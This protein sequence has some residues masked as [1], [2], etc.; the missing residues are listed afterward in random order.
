MGLVKRGSNW[1]IDY[2]D[3][4]G[5]RRLKVVGSKTEAKDLLEQKRAERRAAKLGGVVGGRLTLQQF[6]ESWIADRERGIGSGRRLRSSTVLNYRRHLAPV[7]QRIGGVPLTSISPEHV[8]AVLRALH[9]EECLAPSTI[10]TTAAVLTALLNAAVKARRLA[11][12]PAEGA[13]S[14]PRADLSRRALNT[15]HVEKLLAV[16][17]ERSPLVHYPPVLALAHTGARLG[18]V[19]ALTWADLDLKAGRI[20]IS[21]TSTPQGEI[22]PPKGGRSRT[23]GASHKLLEFLLRL[24]RSSKE[25]ALREGRPRPGS[26][27]LN[28]DGVA[29][30][31]SAFGRALR[32]LAK[33]AGIPEATPHALRHSFAGLLLKGGANVAHVQRALGHSSVK[34]TVD[35]Y[36]S[37]TGMEEEVAALAGR[38]EDLVSAP[39]SD[40]RETQSQVVESINLVK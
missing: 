19:L 38:Y 18:E 31:H 20:S 29:H 39:K 7:L 6:S 34:M 9:D 2:R 15:E 33:R 12:N 13:Y 21:K 3:T 1:A 11:I 10:G 32:R 8:H 26:V 27:F 30:K 28:E 17:K 4:L 37:G 35:L 25:R 23:V 40:F 22:H 36:G 14:R 24:D 16:A 5:V